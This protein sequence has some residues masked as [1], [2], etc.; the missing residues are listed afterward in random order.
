M[1]YD[2]YGKEIETDIDDIEIDME[3]MDHPW[4]GAETKGF[5]IIAFGFLFIVMIL[6]ALRQWGYI[7]FLE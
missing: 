5:D 6:V 4:I 1:I 7:N 2:S 3:K